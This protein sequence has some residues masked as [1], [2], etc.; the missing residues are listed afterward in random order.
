MHSRTVIGIPAS[1]AE[2]GSLET[3]STV[4]YLGYLQNEGAGSVMTTAGHISL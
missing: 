1:Y 3:E 4:R 2:D